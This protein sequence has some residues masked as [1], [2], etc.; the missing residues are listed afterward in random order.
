MKPVLLPPNG[1]PRFYRGGPAITALRGVEFEGERVPE[2]WVG[3]TAKVFGDES[4][5]LSTLPGGELLRDAIAADPEAF[6]GPQHVQR[7]G[8]DPALLVKLLDA[9]ERLPVHVHPDGR[10]ASEHLGTRFGKTEAWIV[11]G[12]DRDDAAVHV[13]FERDVD[14]ATLEQWVREQDHDAMLGALNRVPVGAG[15]AVFV[16]AGTPHAI[17]EGL[18]I[19]ELQEPTDMSVLLEWDGFGIA[20]AGE[21]TLGLGWERALD[22]VQLAAR[23]AEP[24]RGP[25]PREPAGSMLPRGADAFFRAERVA[26]TGTAELARGFAIAIVLA[27]EGTLDTDAGGQLEL[28]RGATVLIPWTAGAAR[29]SGVDAIVCRPPEINGRSE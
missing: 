27:G 10:F 4:L 20:D 17:G 15:D 21:A 18:L 11:V 16:P 8:S 6:L 13:G 3:S 26:P 19:V 28:R 23:S 25:R 24:L 5:G 12:V 22:C 29:L 7:F 9:G 2:E 1:V 14:R